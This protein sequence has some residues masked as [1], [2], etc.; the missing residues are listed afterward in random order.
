MRSFNDTELTEITS[1]LQTMFGSNKVLSYKTLRRRL[2]DGRAPHTPGYLTSRQLMHVLNQS[3]NF[4]RAHPQTVG[5]HKR[6][7]KETENK[8]KEQEQDNKK[9][10][11][12]NKK[13]LKDR[14]KATEYRLRTQ[15]NLWKMC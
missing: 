15:L 2:N 5:S 9:K 13:Q 10:E 1:R 8:N 11:Q 7:E 12:Y 4:Q 14:L 3:N 6:F